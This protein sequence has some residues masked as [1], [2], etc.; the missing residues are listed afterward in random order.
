MGMSAVGTHRVWARD[1]R[2]HME[3]DHILAGDD[4]RDTV[5]VIAD[6]TKT[7]TS[8]DVIRV[9]CQVYPIHLWVWRLQSSQTG[10]LNTNVKAHLNVPTQYGGCA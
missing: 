2:W 7:A 6:R 1:F 3:E 10:I 5:S 8:A 4:I 9:F